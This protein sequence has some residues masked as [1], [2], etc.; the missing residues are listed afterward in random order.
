[1]SHLRLSQVDHLKIKW[2]R[3]AK[4][5]SFGQFLYLGKNKMVKDLWFINRK[6]KFKISN[7]GF[8]WDISDQNL[9]QNNVQ[10]WYLV[11]FNLATS[12]N[13]VS[14]PDN[15]ISKFGFRWL[16]GPLMSPHS[17]PTPISKCPLQM[18]MRDHTHNLGSDKVGLPVCPEFKEGQGDPT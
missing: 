14:S 12:N 3:R 8:E 4:T 6:L 11:P 1:M 10:Q 5:K 17:A 16:Q 15:R 18:L 7:F 13:L 9:L 2:D